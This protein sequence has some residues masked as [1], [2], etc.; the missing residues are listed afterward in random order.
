VL[1]RTEMLRRATPNQFDDHVNSRHGFLWEYQADG[2]L[3]ITVRNEIGFT[4]WTR[5]K[6]SRP[7]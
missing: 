1:N 5:E 7:P 3:R 2:Y 4:I 6:N